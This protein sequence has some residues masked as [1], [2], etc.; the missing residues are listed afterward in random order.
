MF[1]SWHPWKID[2]RMI[3]PLFLVIHHD[4]LEQDRRSFLPDSFVGEVKVGH[5][6]KGATASE[7]FRDT[8]I[9]FQRKA[10]L[11]AIPGTSVFSQNL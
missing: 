6:A 5:C 4:S 3:M 10:A 9:D 1:E 11:I 8:S 7:K 2:T